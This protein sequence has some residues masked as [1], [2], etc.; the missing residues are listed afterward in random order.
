MDL[1]ALRAIELDHQE[2]ALRHEFEGW[3]GRTAGDL[4]KHTSQV[5]KITSVLQQF[6]D[7]AHAEVVPSETAF[8]RNE[9]LFRRLLTAHR[10]WAYFRGKLAMRFVP[11][12]QPDLVCCDEFAWACYKPARDGAQKAGQVAAEQ[13]KEPPLL[14]FT[15]EATPYAAARNETFSPEG[16]TTRDIKDFGEAIHLL[17][18][19]IVGV[20]WFQVQHLPLATIIGHEVGHIVMDDLDLE[21]QVAGNLDAVKD[22]LCGHQEEWSTWLREVFADV[23]GALC[24]GPAYALSLMNYL[25][26]EPETIQER[27]APGSWDAHPPPTLRMHLNF[28]ILKQMKIDSPLAADFAQA[29][30]AAYPD[31]PTKDYEKELPVVAV[32]MLDGKLSTFNNSPLRQV[33]N[34]TQANCVRA[35]FLANMILDGANPPPEEPFRPLFAAATLA[36]HADPVTYDT[37]NQTK[38]TATRMLVSVPRGKRA[39]EP[40]PTAADLERSRKGEQAAAARLLALS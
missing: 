11:W 18:V 7:F 14:F 29:W 9:R 16:V 20:P 38:S 40:E 34:F 10:L 6:L 24:A 2:Q 28:E 8:A 26:G 39:A 21:Q 4:E 19:P 25:T 22:Q 31:N 33:I 27:P 35:K 32:Q 36:Y 5:E 12:L 13:L 1:A 17:P 37:K 30:D 23:Y 15:G 3:R